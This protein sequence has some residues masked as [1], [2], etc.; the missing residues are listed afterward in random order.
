MQ[1][2]G[3]G[4]AQAGED[5]DDPMADGAWFNRACNLVNEF[6][7]QPFKL[8]L[9][10]MDDPSYQFICERER[11]NAIMDAERVEWDEE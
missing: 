5:G 9:G 3:L 8:N 10:Y 6:V 1:G 4:E 2:Q 7:V 11:D